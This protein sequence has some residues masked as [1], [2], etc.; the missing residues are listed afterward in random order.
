MARINSPAD[1]TD[2]P[3]I[4]RDDVIAFF[5]ERS[6]RIEELGPIRAVIYQ[7]KHPDLAERRDRTEKALIEP[8][9]ELTGHEHLLDLGCGSGRWAGA[10][11]DRVGHYHGLDISPGL[12]DYARS[13]FKDH[14]HARFSVSTVDDFSLAS[15][16]EEK[17][18]DR[19]LCSG[20]LIYLNDEELERALTCIANAC[21]EGA[22]VLLREPTATET[23]LTILQHYSEELEHVYNAI[24]RTQAELEEA[25]G[26][27]T[28]G[29]LSMLDSGDVYLDSGLNN[30]AET[31]QRWLR[32]VRGV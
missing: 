4:A 18:F 30:R 21:S 17:P 29:R 12:I 25:I 20:V 7:D 13:Q 6:R 16:G 19:I 27:A 9:L 15:I 8:L 23:R 22:Y 31:R 28:G 1:Q 32:L 11:L 5:E 2:K 26:S 14:P 24:Y 3:R 10:L